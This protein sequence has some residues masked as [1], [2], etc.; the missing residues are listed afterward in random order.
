MV[1][2][3]MGIGEH[4]I[5]VHHF[6]EAALTQNDM[7]SIGEFEQRTYN[8]LVTLS[9]GDSGGWIDKGF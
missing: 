8:G 6:K 1:S 2:E 4:R 9:Q 5:S 7:E 3:V